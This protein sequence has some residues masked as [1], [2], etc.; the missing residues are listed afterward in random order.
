MKVIYPNFSYHI[1]LLYRLL[2]DWLQ[3]NDTQIVFFSTL[4]I[5]KLTRKKFGKPFVQLYEA[6]NIF[7]DKG[8][9]PEL[10]LV[11]SFANIVA[12]IYLPLSESFDYPKSDG[13]S[14]TFELY[15]AFIYNVDSERYKYLDPKTPVT[16]NYKFESIDLHSKENSIRDEVINFT[17]ES[18][19]FNI[20]K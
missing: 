4:F 7:T 17:F 13:K 14:P 10:T 1:Y 9:Y 19:D 12:Q 20:G 5:T 2:F 15:P 8:F 3:N 6:N 16:V 11:V 18:G